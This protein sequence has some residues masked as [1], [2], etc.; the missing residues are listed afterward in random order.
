MDPAL[1]RLE[2]FRGGLRLAT[3]HTDTP[4]HQLHNPLTG[5]L[6]DLLMSVSDPGDET[7]PLLRALAPLAEP[8]DQDTG[9]GIS[10]R[11]FPARS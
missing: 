11:L 7:V 10:A 9:S 6:V 8:V 3:L 1:L 5:T 2:R 4:S